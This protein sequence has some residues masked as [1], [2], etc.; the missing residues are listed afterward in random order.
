MKF[1]ITQISLA[2]YFMT[3]I[4]TV[5]PVPAIA[6]PLS[7]VG[8]VMTYNVNEGSDFL[9]VVGATSLPQFLLGV[10]Q[11]LTQVQGTNLPERMKAVARQILAVGPELVSL[12]E[13]DQWYSGT[14]DPVKGACGAMT[15]Q[16]DM[17]QELLGALA[18]QGGHYQVAVQ[19]TQYAFPP[20]PG[21]IPP[22]TYICV[23]V[24]DYNVVLAR[25]DLPWSFSMEQSA[26]WTIRQ[27]GRFANPGR[28]GAAAKV[29]GFGRCP[30][31]RSLVPLHQ[32]PSRVL[33]LEYSG[34]AGW[35]TARRSRQHPDS[36]DH[37]HGLQLAGFSLTAGL[38]LP[39]LYLRG[40]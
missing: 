8:A 40:V 32:H 33:L 39:G 28:R 9:Q 6:A 36:P 19:V 20:T 24:N 37:R 13:V 26:V 34:I 15:V 11:I 21:L 38:N 16:Y 29:V 2:I 12:Q 30:V 27:S 17:V 5:V 25:T 7:G 22:A 23:A 18:A 35:R 1:N 14:Y 31:L 3:V 10:G 4:W